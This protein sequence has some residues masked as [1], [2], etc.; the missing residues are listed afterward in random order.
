LFVSAH[1][2][3]T[4]GRGKLQQIYVRIPADAT[5]EEQSAFLRLVPAGGAVTVEAVRA[6]LPR[7]EALVICAD[8]RRIVGVAA[9][10]VPQPGYRAGLSSAAKSGFALPEAMFPRELGYVAVEDDSRRKGIGMRL[11][12]EV[13]RLAD[14]RGLLAT[15]GNDGMHHKILPQLGF[16]DAGQGW[17]GRHEHVFLTVRGPQPS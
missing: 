9:L 15:T 11:C 2:S 3:F 17:M 1:G 8:G 5:D 6:G 14:G 16:A 12:N 4:E 10:K 7:A 13:I